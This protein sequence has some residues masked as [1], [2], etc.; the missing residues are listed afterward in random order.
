MDVLIFCNLMLFSKLQI[1]LN[2]INM[3]MWE[4]LLNWTFGH[5]NNIL[6]A[7]FQNKWMFKDYEYFVILCLIYTE[8]DELIGHG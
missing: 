8:S 3:G 5:E 7:I 4:Y 1:F 6:W 2:F